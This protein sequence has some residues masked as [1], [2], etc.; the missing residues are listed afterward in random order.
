MGTSNIWCLTI[1]EFIK[2][3][4]GLVKEGVIFDAYSDRLVIKLTSGF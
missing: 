3:C 2:V 4:A 1:E